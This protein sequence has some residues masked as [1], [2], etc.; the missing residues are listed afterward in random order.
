MTPRPGRTRRGQT[1]LTEEL[2]QRICDALLLGADRA[3]AAGYAGVTYETFRQWLKRGE[4]GEKPFAAL[5]AAVR[6]KEA[7]VV[8]RMQGAIENAIQER[9]YPCK[10]KVTVEGAC[11]ACG[12]PYR[13]ERH[14]RNS[15]HVP[16]S[17]TAAA[18]KLERRYPQHYGQRQRVEVESA[19]SASG[20]AD[21]MRE[22]AQVVVAHVTDA[23]TIDL[24]H[25][26]WSEVA[27]R[28]GALSDDGE[29]GAEIEED[30]RVRARAAQ[31]RLPGGT[32]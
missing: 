16:G 25:A 20:L 24:I 23:D 19:M 4:G 30:R 1:A 17:W 26:G 12:A 9:T 6:Q 27:R 22:L 2:Q 13:V 15:I 11:A 31:A 10:A 3:S 7:E 32:P 14:C 8:V 28:R 21:L 5:V 18:W 29:G